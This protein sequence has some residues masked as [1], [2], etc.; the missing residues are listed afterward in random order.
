[1]RCVN[2]LAPRKYKFIYK[3]TNLVNGKIYIG[4]HAT[5]IIRD[6]YKG[7][8]IALK[9]AFKKYGRN[10][11]KLEILEFYE[12]DSKE[13]FNELE[14]KYVEKF[15]STNPEKGYNRTLCCGGGYI[16]EEAYKNRHY[17]H[18]KEAKEKISRANKGKVVSRYSIEASRLSN[19]GKVNYHNESKE[20]S[21]EERVQKKISRKR[22]RRVCQYTLEGEFIQEWD[23]INEAGR[24]LGLD[25]TASSIRIA[26]KDWNRTAKGFKWKYKETDEERCE[27]LTP[28]Y[29]RAT[30][31]K[32]FKKGNMIIEQY[33]LDDNFIQTF[34]SYSS[35]AREVGVSSGYQIKVACDCFPNKTVRSFYWKR[36]K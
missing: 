13:E 6:G 5:D 2:K 22:E 9:N 4:Q 10:N 12:G 7:S 21:Q 27:Q 33:D 18:S 11:F 36:I 34:D 29:K 3:T 20:K 24:S 28:V 14:Q 1:M 8:G 15:D 31:R 16:G 19:I 30:E 35:A 32:F 25:K 23:S 26:C 17:R